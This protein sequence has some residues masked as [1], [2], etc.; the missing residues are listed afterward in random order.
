MVSLRFIIWSVSCS[1]IQD[2]SA[3]SKKKTIMIFVHTHSGAPRNKR[4]YKWD[5]WRLFASW[6]D[7]STW[8]IQGKP[9]VLAG[10]YSLA[11]QVAAT[12]HTR[13]LGLLL[14]FRNDHAEGA[15]FQSRQASDRLRMRWSWFQSWWLYLQASNAGIW[16]MALWSRWL[17]DFLPGDVRNFGYILTV[18][19][20]C[21]GLE[22]EAG[23][24][25]GNE[26]LACADD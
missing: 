22:F 12:L 11:Q 10:V 26:T 5:P 7:G 25:L 3:P 2:L 21:A 20:A 4:R 23:S 16:H 24:R 14:P 19:A 13:S 9:L 17:H 6:N 1:H 18:H 8:N 15:G